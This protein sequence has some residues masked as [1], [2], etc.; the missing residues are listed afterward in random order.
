MNMMKVEEILKENDLSIT[1]ARKT[2]LSAFLKTKKPLTVQDLKKRKKFDSFN[3]SSIYRNITKLI[4]AGVIQAVPGAGEFKSFELV[5]QGG[6][7]HHITCKKC[8]ATQC[9]NVCDLEKSM[10]AM[11]SHAG[12]L[13]TGH[14]VKLIGL[15]K[16]CA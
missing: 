12:F 8:K 14:S 4:D 9:L 7:H 1:E 10:E 6:H 2:V 3:E 13:L 15:C 5:P 16:S 11:A